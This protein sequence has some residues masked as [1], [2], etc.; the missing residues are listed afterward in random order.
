MLFFKTADFITMKNDIKTTIEDLLNQGVSEVIDRA[1]LKKRLLGGEKLRIKYG[2][3]PTRPDLHL[4][5]WAGMRKLK[6]L[7]D[8]GHKIIFIIGDFT[9]RIGDPSERSKTRPSMSEE[10]IEK[11]SLTYFDQIGKILDIS[12][13]EIRKNS[14]WFSKMNLGE[15]IKLASNFTVARIIER[16]DF[17][18]RLKRGIDIGLHELLYPTM[19]AYDSVVLDIDLE[20]AGNDQKFNVHAARNLQKKLGKKEQDILL[21]PLLV[22]LDGKEK[23]SKSLDNYV[24]ITDA[25]NQMFGKIMSIPDEIVMD[26]FRLCTDVAEEEINKTEKEIKSGNFNWRDAKLNLA[27]E[28]VKIFHG[29]KTAQE[30]KIYFIETFSRR[31]IPENIPEVAVKQK[32]IKLAEFLVLSGNAKSLSD[33]KRKIEQGGVEIDEKRVDD[34]RAILDNK[35][36]NGSILKIGKFGFVKIKFKGK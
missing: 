31:K 20:V 34:W 28:I 36:N 4:G 33:A 35:K 27:W 19:Q 6:I 5:H 9:A 23:M 11:N 10:E 22:G 8:L 14:D 30:A 17:Q 21:V 13:I 12:K 7:Q 3:D 16:D 32:N 26:Y 25:P 2:A 18:K 1:R 29:E 15:I 24:G